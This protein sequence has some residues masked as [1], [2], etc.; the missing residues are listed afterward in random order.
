MPLS[1]AGSL[2]PPH[3]VFTHR[4]LGLAAGNLY[5]SVPSRAVDINDLVKITGASR[6]A[7][8]TIIQRL[9]DH[10]LLV[11]DGA[12]WWLP[13]PIRAG[14]DRRDAVA[15]ALPDVRTRYGAHPVAGTLV[16]RAGAHRLDQAVFDWWCAEVAWRRAPRRPDAKRRPGRG[17]LS[18]VPEEGTHVYG[19]FP[20]KTNGKDDFAAARAI[21]A[22]DEEAEAAHAAAL[23]ARFAPAPSVA[24][25]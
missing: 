15:A 14:V 8:L 25:A 16:R 12:T 18:L 5:A 9:A 2:A 6:R 21:L 11:S 7:A 3:D 23:A 4:A 22:G 19:P 17:Q 10:G 1:R 13:D 24:A 20:T